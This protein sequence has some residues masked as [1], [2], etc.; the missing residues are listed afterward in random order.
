MKIFDFNVH[1]PCN[2]KSDVNET[3]LNEYNMNL[4]QLTKC[5][6]HH[7]NTLKNNQ[8]HA[9][10]FML[11]NQNIFFKNDLSSFI[12]NINNDFQGSLISALIDFRQQNVYEYLEIAVKSGIKAIKF[13]SYHQKI[14]NSDFIDITKICKYAEKHNLIICIDTSYGT[15]KMYEYDNLKLACFISDFITKTPIVL[16][17]SGGARI[18][19][20]MLLADEKKNVFLETSFSV[21]FYLNSSIEQDFA[22]AYKK[23]G[24]DKILYGSDFPYVPLEDSIAK[25]IVYF[26]K[27]NFTS[28]EI[29]KIMYDNATNLI[30]R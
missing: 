22:F 3:V 5:Y 1:L 25:T 15:S 27:Y 19:E 18:I 8:V 13:H 17:H 14:S 2:L 30:L 12:S 24:L 10:N 11:F 16:L 29:E 9:A 23:I 28:K 7:K 21:L 6:T 20:A 26:E 4:E